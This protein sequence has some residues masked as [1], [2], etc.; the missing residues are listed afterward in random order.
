MPS[1]GADGDPVVLDLTNRRLK[2]ATGLFTGII[3]FYASATSGGTV[4]QLQTITIANGLISD[5][6]QGVAGTPG[7]WQFNDAV[8]SGQMLTIGF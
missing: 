5:W 7:E 8:N 6:T 1:L 2:F 4:D 3:T